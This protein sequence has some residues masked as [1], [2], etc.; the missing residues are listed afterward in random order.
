MFSAALQFQ[1]RLVIGNV[2]TPGRDQLFEL[3]LTRGHW[4]ALSAQAFMALALS[5]DRELKL[6]QSVGEFVVAQTL[7]FD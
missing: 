6:A 4:L 2:G 5:S 7:R 3:R 1:A